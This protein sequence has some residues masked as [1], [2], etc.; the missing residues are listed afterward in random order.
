MEVVRP[1]WVYTT[2]GLERDVAVAIDGDRIV[3][4]LPPERLPR[5]SRQGLRIDRP[6]CLRLGDAGAVH[7]PTEGLARQRGRHRCQV[8]RVGGPHYGIREVR[9]PLR[10]RRSGGQ[11]QPLRPLLGQPLRNAEAEG[12]QAAGDQPRALDL[13]PVW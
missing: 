8:G 13:W 1:D 7:D 11:D 10:I 12:A 9:C 5:G 3:G 4:L 6:E 2:S